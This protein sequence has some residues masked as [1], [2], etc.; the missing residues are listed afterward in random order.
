ML[1][2]RASVNL[3][4]QFIFLMYFVQ[5]SIGEMKAAYQGFSDGSAWYSSQLSRHF[6]AR[7]I[8]NLHINA[9][10]KSK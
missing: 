8:R 5:E 7:L 3:T 6:Q 9:A 2:R 4:I 1:F 10:I